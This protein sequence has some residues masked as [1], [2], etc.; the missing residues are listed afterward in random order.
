M[1]LSCK[2]TPLEPSLLISTIE[3][4]NKY[5]E[6]YRDSIL[7]IHNSNIVI[8]Y[9]D[10]S[11]LRKLKYAFPKFITWSP[12]KWKILY[13]KHNESGMLYYADYNGENEKLISEKEKPITYAVISPDAKK[14]A[15]ILKDTTDIPRSEGWVKIMNV[16][17]NDIK[18]L[19]PKQPMLHRLTWTADSRNVIFN[20][21]DEQ[22]RGIF[23]VPIVGGEIVNI[24]RSKKG[25]CFS[26]SLS[27]DGKTLAFSDVVDSGSKII[28][29]DMES[30]NYFQLIVGMNA[31]D[32]PSWSPD[33]SS[34]V[35]QFSE[36]IT[37]Y[38]SIQKGIYTI[39]KNGKNNI[40]ISEIGS[41]PC[42]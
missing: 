37:P 10:G 3:D 21:E 15:Y 28:L 7:A 17:G 31:D 23:T 38:S 26:P 41:S 11:G 2:E 5:N 25:L 13:S 6:L 22:G 42:W 18:Q 19:T 30:G 34:I 1:F 33:G 32:L 27:R 24:Y 40:M 8:M 4:T 14:I 9:K 20:G 12:N 39:N 35:Y 36:I 29:L 16:D